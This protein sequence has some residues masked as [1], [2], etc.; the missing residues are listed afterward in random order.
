MLE[1]LTFNSLSEANHSLYLPLYQCA[2]PGII[3]II[4]I[5]AVPYL[6]IVH[7]CPVKYTHFGI[8]IAWLI[9][10]WFYVHVC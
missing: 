5:P 2:G 7:C 6:I 4:I 3:I 1:I 8:M 10:V 9:L